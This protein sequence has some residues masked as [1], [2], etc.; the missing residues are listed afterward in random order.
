MDFTWPG[1]WKGSVRATG[2]E[3]GAVPELSVCRGRKDVMEGKESERGAK[4]ADG[5]T[6]WLRRSEEREPTVTGLQ[7]HH[8]VPTGRGW[9]EMGY[10]S[11][12]RGLYVWSEARVV[13]GRG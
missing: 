1:P 9:P 7:R 4:F 5:E 8:W 3:R 2:Q 12:W 6:Q 13:G 10:Q 11:C